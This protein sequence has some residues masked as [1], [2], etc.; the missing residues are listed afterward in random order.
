M[1]TTENV[2]RNKSSEQ[3]MQAQPKN[4]G[5]QID[6]RKPSPHRAGRGR[7]LLWGSVCCGAALLL[8]EAV[9]RF[10]LGLGTPVLITPDAACG[11][12]LKPNQNVYRFFAHISTN[13]WGMRSNEVPA[14]PAA[15]TLRLMF[16]GDSITYGT[17]RIDQRDIF[18]ELVHRQLPDVVH[19]P[20]E[21][22]NASAGAWAIGNELS[23]LRSRGTFG[24]EM[25]IEVLNSGD[26]TERFATISDVSSGY[27]VVSPRSAIGELA[28][29]LLHRESRKQDAGDSTID[30]S[31]T[32]RKRNLEHLDEM[33]QLAEQGHTRFVLVYIPFRKEMPVPSETSR[34]ILANWCASRH[35]PFLDLTDFEA[36]Y[37]ASQIT[38]EGVHLNKQGN[39]LAA[40]YLEAHLPVQ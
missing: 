3:E 9:L 20:V 26:L 10:A 19:R 36:Q 4:H 21:V 8:L 31:G 18:T 30:D 32:I 12:V 29:R 11:Y 22:L 25:V 35:V 15:G 40:E 16:L 34:K 7:V 24:S 27:F 33:R 37:A 28:G 14:T 38:L 1:S 13:Q 2:I 5:V 17:S 23:Y 39:A 6:R